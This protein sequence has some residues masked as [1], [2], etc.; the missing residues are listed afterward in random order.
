MV[1]YI[2]VF[3]VVIIAALYCFGIN[4]M[5]VVYAKKNLNSVIV[6]S[7][8]KG[9]ELI[10][11][12]EE[13]LDVFLSK[14]NLQNCNKFYIEDRLVIEG[15]SSKFNNYILINN[16]PRRR[17]TKAS[18]EKALEIENP[19]PSKI[20]LRGQSYIYGIITDSRII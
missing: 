15:Y 18:F 16:D 19:T 10:S 13:N 1:R 17:I 7:D 20:N 4:N 3:F 11:I 2:G 5:L 12:A 14:L 9:E 8:K 6:L